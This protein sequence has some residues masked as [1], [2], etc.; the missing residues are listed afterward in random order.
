MSQERII[1]GLK[2]STPFHFERLLH[3]TWLT[4][5]TVTSTFEPSVDSP[6]DV[7]RE[8]ARVLAPDDAAAAA[9]AATK[10]LWFLVH[11]AGASGGCVLITPH[12]RAA[13]T[14]YAACNLGLD[15]LATIHEA[16]TAAAP[17]LLRG[18]AVQH[19]THVFLPVVDR[20][21]AGSVLAVLYLDAPRRYDAATLQPYVEALGEA[22]LV[23]RQLVFERSGGEV[24]PTGRA[25]LLR[26][27]QDAEWNVARAARVLGVTRRTVYL[28]LQRYG[29]DRQRIPKSVTR[30]RAAR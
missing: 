6:A 22:L 17:W 21:L 30:R 20:E 12:E 24:R 1:N 15:Q 3:G 7:A 8:L 23:S 16:W 27:L 4:A 19:P 13:P 26:V 10:L 9:A 29:I 28:R 5:R 25:G 2:L 14:Q 18:Q 11:R